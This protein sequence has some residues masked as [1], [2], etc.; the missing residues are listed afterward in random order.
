MESLAF[1][2]VND[3]MGIA[4][5]LGQTKA[6]KAFGPLLGP[7]ENLT[8]HRWL[9]GLARWTGIG[10]ADELL[11]ARAQVAII[12]NGAEGSEN[13][14]T[15]VIKPLLTFI[16][17]THTS[18]RRMRATVE[19]HLEDL[20][21][22]N[23]GNPVASRKQIQGV[24]LQ[25]WQ[26]EDASRRIVAAFVNTTVV[27]ANDESA[28]LHSIEAGTGGR[29]TL[30][31]S[32]EF[33]TVRHATKTRNPA[34]FGFVSQSGVRALLQA[35]V[36]NAENRRGISDD[37]LTKA[38]LFADL[39]GGLIKHVGWTARFVDGGVE[40]HC[41]VGLAEGVTDKLGVSLVPDRGPDLTEL[42][43]VP[44]DVHSFS[45]YKFHDSPG[46]WT[47][48]N[49]VV[50]SHADLVGAIAAR[51]LLKNLLKAYG[52]DD[53]DSFTRGIGTR[54]QT[55]RLHE[56]SPAVLV[57]D[58]FDRPALEKAVN[59]RLG[60][61]PKIEK[62]GDADLLVS[63]TDNWTAGFVANNFLIG[64]GEDVRRCLQAR[65]SSQSVLST[66]SF[67]QA[68]KIVDVSLPLTAVSFTNDSRAAI[69]FVETFSA[70]SRSTFSA[71]APAIDQAGRTL[72]LAVSV[73][74]VK[75]G[76]L[77]WTSRSSF[78]IGGSLVTQLFAE[79]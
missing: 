66:D 22:K 39:F 75:N 40:D 25:E 21:R 2:E 51:P 60:K 5:G 70:Q 3:L 47:D 35:Y 46:V 44:P 20:A 23:F 73:L 79:K 26:S 27:V 30:K 42:S 10:S 67:R 1:V 63:A 56:D 7:G 37:S 43:F 8:P 14:S 69:S 32:P 12:L 15:L 65:A 54:L 4:G 28:V 16:I 53:P 55:I 49:A 64:P 45:N 36:L 72:P 57:A 58:V 59:E 74:I 24:E 41:W 29:A 31:D 78:G 48:V 18:Q 71:N 61:N 6:W 13:G 50:S 62:M 52:I 19:R 9:I 68:Q 17:D 11:L 34:A 76:S 33:Q 38:R 77:D